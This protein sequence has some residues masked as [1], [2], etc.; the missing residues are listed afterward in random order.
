MPDGRQ[1]LFREE[2]NGGEIEVEIWRMAKTQ[3][4]RFVCDIPAP[5][6][7]GKVELADGRWLSS[8]IAE[9]G[10]M[11]G[12]TEITEFKGWRSYMATK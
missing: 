4:G 12:A 6:G 5:L 2:E 7:I 9:P 3:F 1:A 8:F 10:A 11:Q